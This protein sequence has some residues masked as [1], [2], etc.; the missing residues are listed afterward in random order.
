MV[1]I[2]RLTGESLHPGCLNAFRCCVSRSHFVQ[3][4]DAAD[5]V[6]FP[7]QDRS[8]ITTKSDRTPTVAK[9]VDDGERHGG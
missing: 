9:L 4:G 5:L 7:I 2:E 6:G 3:P 8:G 1:L